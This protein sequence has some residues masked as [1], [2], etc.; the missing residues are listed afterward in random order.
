V[1]IAMGA[2]HVKDAFLP[3]TGVSLRIPE[4][5]RP[6]LY[7]RV[8][9]VINAENLTGALLGVAVLAFFVN[10]V[11]LLCT[12][13]LP[14]VYTR[15]LT[16]EPR[17]WWSYYG[18]LALY[19]AAYVADDLLVLTVAVVTLGRRRLAEREGRWL[20]ALSGAL[21]LGLGLLLV[22]RPDWLARLGG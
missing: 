7:A 11:E 19:N 2:I 3:G 4:S 1:A 5:A 18:Y 8:R 10:A 13:G 17:P 15:I 9:R 12:A 21:M 6:G 20:N 14:A 22:A 16:L